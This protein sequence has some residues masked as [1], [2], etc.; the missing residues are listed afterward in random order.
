MSSRRLFLTVV[1][2]VF[3]VAAMEATSPAVEKNAA[4]E[5]VQ[6]QPVPDTIKLWPGYRMP[7][8]R[9][10]RWWYKVPPRVGRE[11]DLFFEIQNIGRAVAR[12]PIL[13]EVTC[14]DWGF[15]KP[16]LNRIAVSY[17]PRWLLPGQS[18]VVH[19]RFPMTRRRHNLRLM[20]DPSDWLDPPDN[21]PFGQKAKLHGWLSL[22]NGHILERNERNNARWVCIRVFR[23]K[24]DEIAEIAI[25]VVN[26][27]PGE[28]T[29]VQI[30]VGEDLASLK[31]V[32][33]VGL[34]EESLA[35]LARANDLLP[36]QPVEPGDAIYEL[37]L[38]PETVEEDEIVL[39]VR[40][41]KNAW[42]DKPVSFQVLAT[43]TGQDGQSIEAEVT[44][45]VE[46]ETGDE[47]DIEDVQ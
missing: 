19:I 39:L 28:P 27:L 23:V 18:H 40:L 34:P 44:V 17:C 38:G 2:T 11:V 8:L 24:P 4:K 5:P 6:V 35:H 13:Y 3:A 33:E 46:I 37:A 22:K 25:P 20:A 45:V 15:W 36:F 26:P 7:D 30:V 12:G 14:H 31:D 32:L 1:M 9:I 47:T 29:K 21:P 41:L 42:L 10:G 16:V 43:A